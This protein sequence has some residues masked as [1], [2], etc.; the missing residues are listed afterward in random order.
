MNYII[1]F[2]L[3]YLTIIICSFLTCSDDEKPDGDV[4][5]LGNVKYWAYNIQDV[6]T[7]RQ[8]DQLVGSHFDMYVLEPVV[9]ENGEENFDIA[10]LVDD[11]RQYNITTRNVNPIILAY[12]DIGQA[13]T[14]RWYWD[15]SWD[16]SNPSWIVG[17]DP[18]DWDDCYVVEY[19]DQTWENI[20]IYGHNGISHIEESL[21]AG[22][23][24]IYMDWVEGFDDT[25]VIQNANAQGV[26]PAVA[27][28]DFIQKIRDYAR[29]DSLNKNPDYLIVAQ[30]ASNLYEENSSRYVSLIDAIACEGVWYDG[31]GGFDNWDDSTGY[32]V[33]TNNIY[34]GW[35]EE[36]VEDLNVIKQHIP[37]FCVEYAQDVGGATTAT[38]AYNLSSQHG[39]I[40]YCSRRSLSQLSTTP[41]PPGYSP[42]DY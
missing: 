17:G 10:Q 39:F 24:G 25:R 9:T 20:V 3:I 19:W 42:A 5:R 12:I 4:N 2:I 18:D 30:N 1:N 34:S 6:N 33:P 7:Q 8:R 31:S 14:W 22:F 27:M 11:I 40:C 15:G 36:V 32:N 37:V 13:E 23:D 21:K 28:F 29:N 41:Y 35:T 38:S 16:N 26:D